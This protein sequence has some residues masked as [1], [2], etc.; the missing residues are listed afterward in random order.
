MRGH[1]LSWDDHSWT[2]LEPLSTPALWRLGCGWRQQEKQRATMIEVLIGS[3]TGG[4]GRRTRGGTP[5]GELRLRLAPTA[6]DRIAPF[7]LFLWSESKA[8]KRPQRI[9]GSRSAHTMWRVALISF[10]C[11][12]VFLTKWHNC[13]FHSGWSNHMWVHLLRASVWSVTSSWM[14]AVDAW[15]CMCES[16]A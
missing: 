11:K 10:L 13:V 16:N 14:S 8:S 12:F 2:L 5:W 1:P 4:G 6:A 7:A 15:R 3:G 9:N